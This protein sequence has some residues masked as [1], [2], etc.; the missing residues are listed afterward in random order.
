MN[1]QWFDAREK[2]PVIGQPVVVCYPDG[3]QTVLTP[4]PV[5]GSNGRWEWTDRHNN[6][7]ETPS[8]WLYQEG[9]GDV[10]RRVGYPW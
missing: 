9:G 3:R 1:M 10:H 6:V 8:M 5:E 7:R 4:W 2:Q